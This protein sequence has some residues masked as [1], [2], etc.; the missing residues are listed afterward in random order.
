MS[1]QQPAK[2]C[3][4]PVDHRPFDRYGLSQNAHLIRRRMCPQ[5]PVFEDT[6]NDIDV[7][8]PSV[9]LRSVIRTT[10]R[11]MIQNLPEARTVRLGFLFRTFGLP[12]NSG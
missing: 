1:S 3:T 7:T 10:S 11:M 4:P 9:R 5:P 6:P 12:E 8:L 2:R